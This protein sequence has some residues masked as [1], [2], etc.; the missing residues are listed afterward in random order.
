M[1]L[2]DT[3][4]IYYNMIPYSVTLHKA[5]K[6]PLHPIDQTPDSQK[7]IPSSP[8]RMSY[9]MSVVSI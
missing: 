9:G 8:S 2:D 6:G 5:P 7:A 3:V 1:L 4:G